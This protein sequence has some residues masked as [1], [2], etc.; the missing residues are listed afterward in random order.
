VIVNYS[1]DDFTVDG[2]TVGAL[3]FIVRK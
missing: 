1:E 3:D 2:K